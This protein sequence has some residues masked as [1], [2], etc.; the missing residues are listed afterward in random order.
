MG[1]TFVYHYYPPQKLQIDKAKEK[2]LISQVNLIARCGSYGNKVLYKNLK[3]FDNIFV[4]KSCRQDFVTLFMGKK[5][6]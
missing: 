4:R 6:C 2:V 5:S 3:F 1:V